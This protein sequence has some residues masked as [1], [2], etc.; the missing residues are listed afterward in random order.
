MLSV[1]TTVE[2][3]TDHTAV[4]SRE[5]L[6]GGTSESGWGATDR[7]RIRRSIVGGTVA[8][9]VPFLLLLWDFA[10]DPLRRAGEHGFA[11]NFYDLHLFGVVY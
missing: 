2:E 4:A 10:V 7:V 9:F 6:G 11:S 1:P 3:T 8:G 5:E